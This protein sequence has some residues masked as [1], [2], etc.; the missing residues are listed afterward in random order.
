VDEMTTPKCPFQAMCIKG[1]DAA[2]VLVKGKVYTIVKIFAQV[3]YHI[4]G[5][6]FYWSS[7]RFEILQQTP[8]GPTKSEPDWRAW[9]RVKAGECACAIPKETCIYHKQG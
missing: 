5:C 7:S 9:A 2:G 8:N 3:Y 1:T 4:D 6:S